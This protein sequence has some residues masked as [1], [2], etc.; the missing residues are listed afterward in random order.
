ME[1]IIPFK[2]AD[3]ENSGVHKKSGKFIAEMQRDWEDDFFNKFNTYF[4]NTIEAHPSAMNRFNLYYEG[5]ENTSFNFGMELIDGEIDLDTNLAIEDF[6]EDQT[7]FAIG[8]QLHNNDDNPLFLIKNE[9]LKDDILVFK[10]IDDEGDSPD[11]SN[12][13]I[14]VLSRT[15]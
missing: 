12:Q 10:Y 3:F 9:H 14:N 7:V 5:G 2:K 1:L 6:N 11:E 8:S 4:A 15:L 13:P